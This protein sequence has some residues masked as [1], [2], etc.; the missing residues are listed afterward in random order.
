MK[1][2]FIF[3]AVITFLGAIVIG[4]TLYICIV[5]SAKSDQRI[6]EIMDEEEIR[7]HTAMICSDCGDIFPLKDW[8]LH[9]NCPTCKS[10]EVEFMVEK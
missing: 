9:N 6:N 1:E 2:L 7:Q 5:I 8:G 3:I 4:V 10:E